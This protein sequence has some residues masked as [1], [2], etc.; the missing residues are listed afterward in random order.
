M[1]PTKSVFDSITRACDLVNAALLVEVG[2]GEQRICV[3]DDELRQAREFIAGELER[4]GNGSSAHSSTGVSVDMRIN[5]VNVL[6]MLDS[7]IWLVL[8]SKG[9]DRYAK[10]LSVSEC[11][12][13]L[14]KAAS[15]VSK[16]A[17]PP[18]LEVVRRIPPPRNPACCAGARRGRRER[19]VN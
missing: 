11:C 1:D 15:A 7:G 9:R 10:A 2:G 12:I 5:P 8:D 18:E 3:M 19:L 4:F 13:A 17:A 16:L 14:R 6:R